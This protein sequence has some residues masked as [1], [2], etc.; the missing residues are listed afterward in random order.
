MTEPRRSE[1]LFIVVL[2]A[3]ILHAAL[4]DNLELFGARPNLSIVA[5]L[6][7]SLYVGPGSGAGLGLFAGLLEAA[8]TPLYF[9][10]LLAT[11]LIAGAAVGALEFRV[12][13]DNASFA[14]VTVLLG[15]PLVEGLF[16]LFAPQ[17]N[18]A[19]WAFGVLKETA[20]HA[21]LALPAYYLIRR[22]MHGRNPRLAAARRV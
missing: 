2:V 16:Y 22:I 6:I 11:R 17:P 14:F 18:P 15:T 4:A 21:V 8:Y 9:G 1:P 19:V 10:T 12:F 5:L 7:S 3:G 20:Y 13:R